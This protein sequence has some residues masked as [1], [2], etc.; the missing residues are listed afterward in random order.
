MSHRDELVLFETMLLNSPLKIFLWLVP[1][2]KSK[3]ES[4]PMHCHWFF[5]P[6]V[7]VNFYCLFWSCMWSEHYPIWKICAYGQDRKVERS[8]F[9]AYLSEYYAVCSVP[10]IK[11]FLPFWCLDDETSPKSGVLFPNFSLRPVADRHKSNLEFMP[12]N[13]N[14]LLLS[15]IHLNQ[16]RS[17]RKS[18]LWVKTCNKNGFVCFFKIIERLG[19]KMIVVVVTN[20]SC[21]D[22]R[23]SW[24]WAS[25]RSISFRSCKLNRRASCW[26]D[27]VDHQI[28]I[29]SNRYNCGWVAYPCVGDFV[30]R[31]WEYRF[32]DWQL[33]IELL[34]VLWLVYL[35]LAAEQPENTAHF[36]AE[37][38]LALMKLNGE[39]LSEGTFSTAT[40]LFSLRRV[41]VFFLPV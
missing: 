41:V 22:G 28:C 4:S 26:K 25:W 31:C 14:V 17:L 38:F 12:I 35:L 2:F 3:R 1:V 32:D 10:R 9:F 21:M 29:L 16:V 34:F 30:L 7:Q 40:R 27:R 13:H 11:Y 5:A 23:K 24:N 8:K 39:S 19:I 37:G 6:K 36:G 18:I 20:K 33:F 15:P